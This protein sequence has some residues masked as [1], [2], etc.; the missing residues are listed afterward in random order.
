MA[1]VDAETVNSDFQLSVLKE[2]SLQLNPGSM[3]SK[4]PMGSRGVKTSPCLLIWQNYKMT[5]MTWL[6][7]YALLVF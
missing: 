1:T 5:K 3:T 4:T 7:N 6:T 2:E